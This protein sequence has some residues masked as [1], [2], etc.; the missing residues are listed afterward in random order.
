MQK[1]FDFLEAAGHPAEWNGANMI[2]LET[3]YADFKIGKSKAS[4]WYGITRTEPG[5]QPEFYAAKTPGE[6]LDIIEK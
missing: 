4:E 1:L 6:V 3:T 5:K 2:D